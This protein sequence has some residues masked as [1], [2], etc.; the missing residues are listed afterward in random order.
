MAIRKSSGKI[1]WENFF[2]EKA[3]PLLQLALVLD[4]RCCPDSDSP[5]LFST[6]ITVAFLDKKK[7]VEQF[8]DHQ[9]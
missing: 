6:Q 3:L 4:L 5:Y 2:R 1:L 9:F 8:F 7:S